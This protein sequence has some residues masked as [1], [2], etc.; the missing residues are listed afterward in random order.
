AAPGLPSPPRLPPSLYAD[1]AAAERCV[2]AALA[3]L[4]SFA[5]T[6]Q[7]GCEFVSLYECARELDQPNNA[8]L[9]RPGGSLGGGYPLYSFYEASDGWIAIAALEPH[10]AQRLLSELRLASADRSE[11]E[12]IF[13]DRSAAEWERWASERDLPV[14]AV[15]TI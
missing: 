6:A 1:R 2:T 11:L 13:R 15:K 3:L 10:F 5:R 12:R 8:G 4:L 14:V 7:A 9:T